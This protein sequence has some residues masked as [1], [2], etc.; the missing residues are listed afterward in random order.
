MTGHEDTAVLQY[1]ASHRTFPHETTGDQF[2]GR[3]S[4]RAIAAWAGR[5]RW[6]TFATTT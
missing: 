3:I 2:Y 1:K 4:S 6:R 5:S